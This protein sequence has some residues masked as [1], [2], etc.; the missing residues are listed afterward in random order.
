MRG[1]LF[2]LPN[3]ATVSHEKRIEELE[4]KVRFMKNL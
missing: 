1:Y 4:N 3:D 2:M